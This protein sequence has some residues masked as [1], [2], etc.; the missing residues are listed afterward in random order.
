VSDKSRPKLEL[1]P[2]PDVVPEVGLFLAAL[3]D[4][5]RRMR[6]VLSGLSEDAIDK[7]PPDGGSS[8]GTLLYHIALIETDWL[9]FDILGRPESDWPRELFPLDHRLEDSTLTPFTGETLDQHLQR[10]KTVRTMLVD[11][12]SAMTADDLHRLRER[13][14]Y[15][16]SPAWALHHLMQHEAEHRSQIGHVRE[17]IGPSE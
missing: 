3:K 10:L 12:V 6:E 8:I 7:T 13:D 9:L 2:A 5:R 1:V 17:A 15:E 4:T 14:G 11:N 16:V